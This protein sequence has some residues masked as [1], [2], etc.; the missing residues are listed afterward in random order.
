MQEN[1][2]SPSILHWLGVQCQVKTEGARHFRA[3]RSAKQEKLL[4]KSSAGMAKKCL[5]PI[6]QKASSSVCVRIAKYAGIG[7]KFTTP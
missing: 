6:L 2:E 5:A 4:A 7:F 3:S 1:P